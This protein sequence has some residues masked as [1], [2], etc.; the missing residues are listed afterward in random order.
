MGCLCCNQGGLSGATKGSWKPGLVLQ[1][2]ARQVQAKSTGAAW[3]CLTGGC[4]CLQLTLTPGALWVRRRQRASHSGAG[5]TQ[6]QLL[7]GSLPNITAPLPHSDHFY[8]C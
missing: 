4:G 5:E 2:G 3:P 6:G 7:T 1:E 8:T